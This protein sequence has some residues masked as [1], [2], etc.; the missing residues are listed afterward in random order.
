MIA[1]SP[2]D[3]GR[4]LWFASRRRVNDVRRILRSYGI[5]PMQPAWSLTWLWAKQIADSYVYRPTWPTA[6]EIASQ[7]MLLML[8]AMREDR[9]LRLPYRVWRN[10]PDAV[11]A[12]LGSQPAQLTMEG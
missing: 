12:T 8:A 4:S 3:D 6:S 10:V 7:Y 1:A 5:R 2:K 11:A 9:A